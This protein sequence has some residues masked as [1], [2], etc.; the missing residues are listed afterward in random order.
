MDLVQEKPETI[1]FIIKVKCTTVNCELNFKFRFV[2]GDLGGD[3]TVDCLFRAVVTG[4]GYGR[5]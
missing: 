4:L 2:S 1:T 5:H 3:G